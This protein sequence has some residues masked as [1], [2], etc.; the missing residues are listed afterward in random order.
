MHR[1]QFGEGG[2]FSRIP[3]D[4]RDRLDSE[5]RFY[6]GRPEW[7]PATPPSMGFPALPSPACLPLRSFSL[8]G[9]GRPLH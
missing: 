2:F 3:E 6:Q 8:T 1:S 7:P 9:R 5:E 4:L